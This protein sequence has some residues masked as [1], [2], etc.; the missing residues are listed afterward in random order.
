MKRTALGKLKINRELQ[1][2]CRHVLCT[3]LNLLV[4]TIGMSLHWSVKSTRASESANSGLASGLT[5]YVRRL[6]CCKMNIHC[7]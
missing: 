1:P 6:I 4:D 3:A 7:S 5:M 2:H